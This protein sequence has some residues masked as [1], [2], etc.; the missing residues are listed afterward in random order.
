MIN[1]QTVTGREQ[2]LLKY[3]LA[4][5]IFHEEQCLFFTK[6]QVTKKNSRLFWTLSLFECWCML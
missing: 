2:G 1:C 3:I 4:V 5:W 6:L